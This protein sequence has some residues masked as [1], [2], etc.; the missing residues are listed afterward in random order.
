M[1][2]GKQF[3]L[4][5]AISLALGVCVTPPTTAANA[6]PDAASSQRRGR[7]GRAPRRALREY[8][9]E[10][11][12]STRSRPPSTAT[13]ATTTSCRIS[14]APS[15]A[16]S[17]HDFTR[18]GCKT[19]RGDRHR[20]ARRP[21]PAQLR[22]LRARCEELARVRAVPR[23]DAAGQPVRQLR[24]LR[25]AARLRHR[26]AAVQDGQGLRQLAGARPRCRCSSTPPSRTCARASRPAWCSRSVLM[27]KVLP[28]LDA[29]IKDKP[30]DTL[31]WGPIK[32]CRRTSPR[33]TRRG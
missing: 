18:G 26:R 10:V 33:P 17:T 11:L 31:F 14:A 21:G 27:E 12:S 32:T 6:A 1:M 15:T 5:A 23:L 29:L 25:R 19:Q 4:A 7:Q 24:Q 3:L 9:E 22:D 8:W 30:E 13:R 2:L 28:Q 16:S 20:R